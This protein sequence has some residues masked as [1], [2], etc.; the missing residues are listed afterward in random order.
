MG[1]SHLTRPKLNLWFSPENCFS[2]VFPISIKNI[3]PFAK[4]KTLESSLAPLSY[5]SHPIH[6]S[7]L[8][9]TFNR[10]SQPSP[11]PSWCKT[12]S[13]LAKITATPNWSP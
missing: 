1:I 3:R 7:I 9:P 11:F 2:H 4:A 10:L 6:Q 12:P 5:I 13:S 8:Y